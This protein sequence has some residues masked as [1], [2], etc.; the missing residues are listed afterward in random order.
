MRKKGFTPKARVSPSN[1]YLRGK[2]DWRQKQAELF[3]R[4]EIEVP[5]YDYELLQNYV[6]KELLKDVDVLT[7]DLNRLVMHKASS[8]LEETVN[9][10]QKYKIEQEIVERYLLRAAAELLSDPGSEGL[11]NAYIRRNIEVY[12]EHDVNLSRQVLQG[13]L[14]KDLE[15]DYRDTIEFYRSVARRKFYPLLSL[16]DNLRDDERVN[17]E[18]ATELINKYLHARGLSQLGW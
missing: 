8:A 7:E 13:S 15:N 16:L 10:L 9:L 12:G 4:G 6:R 1:V 3:I 11:L 5:E 17:A 2:T 14:A 18:R